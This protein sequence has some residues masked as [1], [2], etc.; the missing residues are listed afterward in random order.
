MSIDPESSFFDPPD[1]A[2]GLVLVDPVAMP[3]AQAPNSLSAI[4]PSSALY[5][6]R[7]ARRVRQQQGQ[8]AIC[9]IRS[10]SA[11]KPSGRLP[12]R[13]DGVKWTAEED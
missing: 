5:V 6:L 8:T 9:R 4:Q 13:L 3:F 11:D 7:T 10:R 2:H 12:T 1:R